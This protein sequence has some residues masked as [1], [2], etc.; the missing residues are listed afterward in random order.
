MIKRILF[1][2]DEKQIL[3]ALNRLFSNS[4]YTIFLKESGE[5][6]LLFLESNPVDLVVSDIRMPGM[7]GFELLR[8][9]KDTYP[10]VMR[11]A[12]SGFTDSRQIYK[13]LEDNIAKMYL[14]KP[15]DNAE[16]IRI[17]DNLFALERTLKDKRVLTLIN[18][19]DTL[20][21]LPLLYNKIRT[22]VNEDEDVEKIAKLIESDQSTAAKILRIANSAY[23]GNKTGSIAQAIMFIGLTNIKSIVLSSSVFNQRHV[24]QHILELVWRS[25]TLTNRFT[26]LF[27]TQ[28]LNKKIPIVYASAGLMHNIGMVLLLSSFSETYMKVLQIHDNVGGE[29]YDIELEHFGV[30][31]QEIGGYLL[32]WWEM[33]LAMV[34]VALYH[35]TP[36]D[37]RVMN[38]ELLC[39]V[40]LANAMVWRRLDKEEYN[41]EF[42][43]EGCC[44]HLNVD[45]K[46]LIAFFEQ[47]ELE[48]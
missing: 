37:E 22:M 46:Q 17:I 27:Y 48:D 44:R 15:W 30:T 32:N 38:K 18:N 45:F 47:I 29:L 25:A 23:Y 39:A 16:L 26:N 7:N 21:T 36:L 6:A 14:F 12:L 3:R 42:Y 41:T 19:L 34:E 20:P 35:H 4:D 40:Y 5:E 9:I 43:A 33:P 31:H 28:F 11:V 10:N 24:P 2:D 1:V 8:K 13:A